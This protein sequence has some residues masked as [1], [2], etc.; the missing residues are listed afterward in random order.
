MKGKLKNYKRRKMLKVLGAGGLAFFMGVGTLCGVLI[1]PMGATSASN[2]GDPAALA[3]SADSAQGL[4]T[5]KEDDPVLFT[6]ENGLEIKFGLA[7]MPSSSNLN[8][9]VYFTTIKDN[10]TY[11]WVIIGKSTSGFD[12]SNEHPFSSALIY[13]QNASG[14]LWAQ[15][16]SSAYSAISHDNIENDIVVFPNFSFDVVSNGEIPS[17][18]VL[19]LSNDNI[20]YSEYGNSGGYFGGGNLETQTVVDCS[21]ET[22]GLS[23]ISSH[24]QSITLNKRHYTGGSSDSYSKV[25]IFVLGGDSVSGGKSLDNFKVSTYLTPD[26]AKLSDPFWTGD[27]YY[28]NS[29]GYINTS[30]SYAEWGQGNLGIRP[31]F[32]LKI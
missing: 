29:A 27:S 25:R 18:C 4:I 10:I 17:G 16:Y 20:Y 2:S 5:P 8:G 23:I 15:E 21:L 19:C 31:A 32:C 12:T 26:E 24:I 22:L 1:A 7:T 13:Y 6:T 11:T 3:Q 14:M 30:G 9:F 28:G